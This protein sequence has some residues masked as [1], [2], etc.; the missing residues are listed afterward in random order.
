MSNHVVFHQY[1]FEDVLFDVHVDK[2][3]LD[4]EGIY[5]DVEAFAVMMMNCY[6]S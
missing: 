1:A 4:K 2:T 5:V 6:Q 3:T